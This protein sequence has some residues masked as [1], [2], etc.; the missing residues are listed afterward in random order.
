MVDTKT[1]VR[2]IF[3]KIDQLVVDLS[4]RPSWTVTAMLT[5]LT[6]A[7]VGLGVALLSGR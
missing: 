5:F 4:A 3:R 2:E 6:S 1:D 7:V